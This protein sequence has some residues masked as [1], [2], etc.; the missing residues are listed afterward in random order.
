MARETTIPGWDRLNKIDKSILTHIIQESGDRTV[1]PFYTDYILNS[2]KIIPELAKEVQ[3]TDLYRS[4]GVEDS[5][6]PFIFGAR[7]ILDAHGA[8]VQACDD[9][10][11]VFTLQYDPTFREMVVSSWDEQLTIDYANHREGALNQIPLAWVGEHIRKYN[12]RKVAYFETDT[13]AHE[14]KLQIETMT[15]LLTGTTLYPSDTFLP[16]AMKRSVWAMAATP[17]VGAI[18]L[19][20]VRRTRLDLMKSWTVSLRPIQE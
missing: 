3:Q 12:Q 17:L 6:M 11:V 4:A 10:L 13:N 5:R 16:D 7:E 8:L 18:M 2:Q 1:L 14:M 15:A 20:E 9:G 19:K